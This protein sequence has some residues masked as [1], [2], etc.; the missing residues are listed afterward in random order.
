ME[1][2]ITYDK[3]ADAAY[4]YFKDISKGDVKKNNL[5]ERVYKRRFR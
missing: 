4:I 2:K 3:E 5:F 1:M